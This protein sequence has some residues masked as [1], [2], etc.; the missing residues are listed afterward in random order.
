MYRIYDNAAVTQNIKSVT[1]S[2]FVSHL[3]NIKGHGFPFHFVNYG[4]VTR[5]CGFA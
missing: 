3:K 2:L 1:N 4:Y 5:V